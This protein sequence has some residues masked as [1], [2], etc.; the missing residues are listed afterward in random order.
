MKSAGTIGNKVAMVNVAD[1]FGIELANAAR[2]IFR[3]G[4]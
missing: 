4:F 2:P 3:S 1:A